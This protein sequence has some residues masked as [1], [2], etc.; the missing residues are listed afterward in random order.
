MPSEPLIV[1][2]DAREA[3]SLDVRATAAVSPDLG[4]DVCGE[5]DGVPIR[6]RTTAGSWEEI[7]RT[8]NAI[9]GLWLAR[10]SDVRFNSAKI[11][12]LTFDGLGSLISREAREVFL[13][14]C[15]DR[16]GGYHA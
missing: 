6:V 2:I 1:Y 5:I 10:P 4:I 9:R 13:K 14:R 7:N 16:E 8:T 3:F 11:L 12:Q 15:V